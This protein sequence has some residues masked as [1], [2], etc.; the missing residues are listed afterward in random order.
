MNDPQHNAYRQP[1]QG[2]GSVPPERPGGAFTTPLSQ[3]GWPR[4]LVYLSSLV[5]GLYLL[6]P[7]LGVF[8]LLPDNLPLVGNLD[9]A[10]AFMLVWYGLIEYAK[11]RRQQP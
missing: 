2:P 4:W 1:P 3:R 11:R 9:E 7:G 8:E 5:G 6:N 10:G